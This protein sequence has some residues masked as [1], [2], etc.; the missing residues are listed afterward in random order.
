M[1]LSL[2]APCA[3]WPGAQEPSGTADPHLPA[4]TPQPQSSPQLVQLD[5]DADVVVRQ[6][7]VVE[8]EGHQAVFPLG[9]EGRIA[10]LDAREVQGSQRVEGPQQ[11]FNGDPV[12]HAA[13]VE[14]AQAAEALEGEV[15][16]QHLAG[17]VD[18]A[19]VFTAPG[20]LLLVED[21]GAA[22]EAQGYQGV[23]E[24]P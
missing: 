11:G 9:E 23:A 12:D 6:V 4:A 14:E 5:D 8:H 10:R 16:D 15:L 19:L 22:E 1:G 18:K 7:H 13:Q 24:A 3:P 2:L 20:V 21:V 17:G